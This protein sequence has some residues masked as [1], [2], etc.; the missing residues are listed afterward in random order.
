MIRL[1]SVLLALVLSL[2]LSLRAQNPFLR[3]SL[4]LGLS[5]S[6]LRLSQPSGS[7]GALQGIRGVRVGAGL[8][9]SLGLLTYL[10][11]GLYYQQQGAN[12]ELSRRGA[13]PLDASRQGGIGSEQLRMGYLNVPLAVGMRLAVPFLGAGVS[14]ELGLSYS[15]ALHGNYHYQLRDAARREALDY[16]PYR[17][18]G[19]EATALGLKADD[20]ALH[21]A[22]K[23][24]LGSYYLRLGIEHGLTQIGAGAS[25]PRLRTTSSWITVG[26]TLF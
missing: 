19:L 9:L 15:K 17:S 22:A 11:T 14:G 25:S 20:L 13:T 5:S 16:N 4:E 26:Y 21:L 1:G 23:L 12:N 24:E 10:S 8:E 3:P 18:G 2:P 6:N 7:S